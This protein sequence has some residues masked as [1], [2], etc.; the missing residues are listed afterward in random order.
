MARKISMQ[1]K[2]WPEKKSFLVFSSYWKTI[3][4]SYSWEAVFGEADFSE[5]DIRQGRRGEKASLSNKNGLFLGTKNR[6]WAKQKSWKVFD[7]SFLLTS[8]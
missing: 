7:Y 8:F 2:N 6:A 5:W 4:F 1:Y 3:T